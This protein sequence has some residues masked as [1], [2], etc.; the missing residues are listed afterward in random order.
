MAASVEG[1]WQRAGG[2][3]PP[4]ALLAPPA[5]PASWPEQGGLPPAVHPGLPPAGAGFV[6]SARLE[7]QRDR[8]GLVPQ[9]VSPWSALAGAEGRESPQEQADLMTRLLQG[10][11]ESSLTVHEVVGVLE[12]DLKRPAYSS[13][14]LPR[15][16]SRQVP[17]AFPRGAGRAE[18]VQYDKATSG[19]DASGS[20]CARCRALERQLQQVAQALAG[21]GARI[22]NWTVQATIY[23]SEKAALW[24][25]TQQYL[26][27]CAHLDGRIADTCSSLTAA[28]RKELRT[29]SDKQVQAQPGLNFPPP[30]GLFR[31]GEATRK[32]NSVDEVLVSFTASSEAKKLNGAYRRRTDMEVNGRPVYCN[33]NRHILY[34]ADG[35]WVI[36]DGHGSEPGA[37]VYAYVEDATAEEPFGV[38]RPWQVMDDG[39][40][41]LEDT[42][43]LVRRNLR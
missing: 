18:D 13:L 21:L 32:P 11:E 30:D 41:F 31:Q 43:G 8:K 9:S 1:L 23:E 34:M 29:S 28:L 35:A 20:L 14:S 24:Q 26:Q 42:E 25:L 12:T 37:F 4:S 2:P 3:A 40:G 17:L 36:K 5:P 39:D 15:D 38:R 22:F 6:R 33:G 19:A 7:R 16:E 10:L 27:P